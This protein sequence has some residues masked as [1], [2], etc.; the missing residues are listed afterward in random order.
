MSDAF[1]SVINRNRDF[2]QVPLALY[3]AGLL[4][5]LVTDFYA[6]D[7]LYGLLPDRLSR[8]RTPGLPSLAVSPAWSSFVLQAIGVSLKLPMQGLLQYCDRIHARKASRIAQRRSSHLYCYAD[9]M[10]EEHEIPDFTR[11]IDFEYHPHPAL[12]WDLL[13]KDYAEYPGVS[14]SFREE[15]WLYRHAMRTPTW[16]LAEQIVC[17]SSMTRRS[18][19]FAGCPSEKITVIPYGFAAPSEPAMPRPDGICRFLFVGQGVQRKGLHHLLHAWEASPPPNS[20]LTVICYRIDP[21]I[22]ALV[23]SPSIKLLGRQGRAALDRHFAMADAFV[24]PSLIEGFGLV[25]L[26][27][28][29]A[30]CHVV[31]TTNT[32]LPDLPLSKD[33][34]TILEPGD[35][36][37]LSAALNDIALAKSAR[38]LDAVRIAKEAASW[39][40]GAFRERI[41][42]HARAFLD[43]QAI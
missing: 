7:R 31:G 33:A 3:E 43:R 6:P 4:E 42:A 29:S 16:E 26:E 5:T 2:Y 30:G 32:G 34:A 22:A 13:N 27:A 10:P 25:Y 35:I 38:T 11:V 12:T 37:S 9:Y 40:W 41:A 18:L 39:P 15:E 19:E 21:G 24:M 28:L 17:A 23:K 14:D 8:R 20:E 36:A 1:V